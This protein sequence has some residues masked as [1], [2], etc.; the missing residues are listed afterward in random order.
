[1]IPTPKAHQPTRAARAATLHEAAAEGTIPASSASRASA[2]AVVAQLDG[3][4]LFAKLGNDPD[5][6]DDPWSQTLRLLLATNVAENALA[7]ARD[8]PAA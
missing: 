4:A 6:L 8:G 5:V 2:R 1:M 7:M 3:K